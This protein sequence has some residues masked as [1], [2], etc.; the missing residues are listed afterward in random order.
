MFAN[1]LSKRQLMEA[2]PRLT[3]Y[4][5]DKARLH[6]VT[7]GVGEVTLPK[8]IMSARLNEAKTDH[9]LDFISQPRNKDQ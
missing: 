6:A 5:V 4:R 9:F 2:I 3:V 8:K 7:V 1:N